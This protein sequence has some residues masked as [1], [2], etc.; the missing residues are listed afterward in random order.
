[1]VTFRRAEREII[2]KYT[3]W[4][5]DSK[6]GRKGWLERARASEEF[7]LSDVEDTGTTFTSS[8]Y[9]RIID[10]TNM[11]FSIN[12]LYPI[13]KHEISILAQTKPSMRVISLDGRAKDHAALLD[14]MKHAVLYNSKAQMEIESAIT[15]AVVTGMGHLM[16]VPMGVY[17]G[18]LFNVGVT[19]VPFDE[20][21]LDINAKKRSLEDMEG[22]FIEK[23]FTLPKFITLYSDI[24]SE[25][26]D[27]VTGLNIS[28]QSFT[29]SVWIEDELTPKQEVTTTQWNTQNYAV[30]REYYTK[31]FT[32]M[33]TVPDPRT[34]TYS[35]LF[36]E[37]LDV[38]Q[39]TLLNTAVA[40]YPGIYIKKSLIFGDF[41]TW[42]EVMPITKSPLETLFFEW[43]G[44]P[45]RSYGAPHFTRGTAEAFEKSLQIMILNG[46]LANNSG[47]KAPKGAIAEEDRPK[48][49]DYANNPR[50]IKEYI[51]VTKEGQLFVPEREE[52]GQIGSFFPYLLD[53]LKNGIEY[54]TGITP[55][56]QGNPQEASIDV[57]SSLQQYQNAAMQRIMLTASHINQM[58]VNLGQVLVEY[59][60]ANV[61]P[62]NYLFFDEKGSLNEVK[63]AQE[64]VNDIKSYRYLTV[65]VPA[66]A[67]PTQR[68]A[69]ATEL[70]KIAQSS[71]DPTERSLY[72]QTAMDLAEIREFDDLREKLDVVKRAEQKL[73]ELDTAYKRLMETS[74]QIEN[75]YIN[76]ALENKILNQMM[77][78]NEQIVKSYAEMESQ[79]GLAQDLAKQAVQET[80]Q[81]AK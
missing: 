8:Q 80:K 62:E 65:S 37:N 5:S 39:Q 3:S 18:G 25:I 50:V 2:E 7:Y 34:G 68:L 33:Y 77:R 40:S 19:Y 9:S 58:M 46:M 63:L 75:K 45:Y 74:K 21:I 52:P 66:T 59:L 56:L 70:T 4:K 73:Q 78:K 57:F 67:M 76:A 53:L 60:T 35:F 23:A 1:M 42:E 27:P 10:A 28:A 24:L 51:P 47:W 41:I 54:S 31:V 17:Q 11:P 72:T 30:V 13:I 36:A 61:G 64:I 26:K 49:E 14:K 32:T 81:N 22:F 55:I 43:G 15:D 6:Y 38:D 79:I 16:V 20:V 48:W 44:R 71:P 29:N 12:I 69:M